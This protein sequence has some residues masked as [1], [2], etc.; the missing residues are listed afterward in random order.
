M[1]IRA[2]LL[3][4]PSV[5]ALASL[6]RDR[7]A[8]AWVVGGAPRDGLL[9]RKA[10]DVDIAVDIDAGELARALEAAGVGRAVPISETSP[11]VF[12]VAAR[13]PLD[14]AQLEGSTIEADL[15]R[16]DFTANAIA[17]DLATGHWIDPFGGAADLASRRLRLVRVSNLEEDPLRAFRAARFYA[18]HGLRPDPATRRACLAAAPRLSEAAAERVHAELARMLEAT[19][20][21]PA[22]GWARRAGLLSPALAIDAPPGAWQR[23][24]RILDRLDPVAT[25]LPPGRRRRL[26][27]AGVA[28]ALRLPPEDAAEWLRRRR[29]SRP[30]AGAVASLLDLARQAAAA[31]SPDDRWAW[32]HDA[33][34]LGPDA[35]DLALAAE[36]RLSR[37]VRPIRRLRARRRAGPAVDGTDLIGWLALPPG[38]E[39][40]AM[41]RRVRIEILRGRVRSRAQARRFLQEAR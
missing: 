33:G 3:R 41:L 39:L 31:R 35:L 13:V 24:E 1:A 21:A 9:G 36:P 8:G 20:V 23:A 5:R 12:R 6:A 27:L 32:I 10:P 14:L 40:G 26:R 38:P 11:R 34:D 19:R 30:E 28:A 22:F 18:T 16:R 15:A 4:H 2:S 29:F 17:I 37:I 7:G 25:R